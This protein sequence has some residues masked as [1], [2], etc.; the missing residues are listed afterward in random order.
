[1]EQPRHP[2]LRSDSGD[3]VEYL[4]IP[5][6]PKVSDPRQDRTGKIRTQIVRIGPTED[7]RWEVMFSVGGRFGHV[8]S[9]EFPSH[10]TSK[11]FDHLQHFVD[12]QRQLQGNPTI[13]FDT[14]DPKR[15]K[16][17]MA[18]ANRLGVKAV[19]WAPIELSEVFSPTSDPRERHPDMRSD[20]ESIGSHARYSHTKIDN[21][22][23]PLYWVGTKIDHINTHFDPYR[24]WTEIEFAVNG[25]WEKESLDPEKHVP[26]DQIIGLAQRVFDHVNHYH[27]QVGLGKGILFATKN[28]KKHNLYMRM[29]KRLGVPA[30]NAFEHKLESDK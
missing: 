27:S 21:Q 14:T 22:G 28:R 23:N 15:H 5:K 19:N 18:A 30:V 2:D 16:I 4:H 26:K 8:G 20:P 10:V 24:G 7:N 29:A 6:D 1:M 12:T 9:R 3:Y 11:V 17:Y 25:S 13:H